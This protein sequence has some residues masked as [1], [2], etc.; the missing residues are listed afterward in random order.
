MSFLSYVLPPK[1]DLVRELP[2]KIGGTGTSEGG[3]GPVPLPF[4]MGWGNSL[5]EKH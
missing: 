4:R 1:Y 5:I 2:A 3:S